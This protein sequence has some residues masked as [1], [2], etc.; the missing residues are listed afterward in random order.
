MRA[1]KAALIV[2]KDFSSRYRK[3]LQR[4]ADNGYTRIPSMP[5]TQLE[6]SFRDFD[7]YFAHLSKATRKDL[8]AKI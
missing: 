8:A 2:F 7:D 1:G 6:L 5:M 4:F 3:T